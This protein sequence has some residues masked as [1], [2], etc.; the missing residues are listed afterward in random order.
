MRGSKRHAGWLAAL[1]LAAGCAAPSPA[2]QP[3]PVAPPQPLA[4][5]QPPETRPPAGLS[6][7]ET[8]PGEEQVALRFERFGA[9]GALPLRLLVW[10]QRREHEWAID[11]GVTELEALAGRRPAPL[12][13]A[14]GRYRVLVFAKPLPFGFE[15]VLRPDRPVDIR[16]R[17]ERDGHLVLVET[18][19]REGGLT[20]V[21]REVL[22][23]RWGEVRPALPEP[24][25]PDAPGASF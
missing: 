10:D 5:A 8:V 15:V 12:L 22:G 4:A 16:I 11:R 13:L 9:A 25:A 6:P 1:L 7:T 3:S 21:E 19:R 24:P 23:F 14:P 20:I 17:S 18:R 2:P